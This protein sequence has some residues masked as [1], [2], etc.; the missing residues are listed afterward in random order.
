MGLGAH[1]RTTGEVVYDVG[2]H[3]RTTGEVVYNVGALGR[4][5]V[6]CGSSCRMSTGG[7]LM[8]WNKPEEEKRLAVKIFA[9]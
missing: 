2:A 1:G 4:T 6:Q 3:G 5:T 9:N 7:D 8:I